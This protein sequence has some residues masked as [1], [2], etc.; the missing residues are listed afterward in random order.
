MFFPPWPSPSRRVTLD[1]FLLASLTATWQ[2]TPRVRWHVRADNL[3]DAR[4]RRSMV[5]GDPA[6]AYTWACSSRCSRKQTEDSRRGTPPFEIYTRTGDAGE[7]GI[8]ARR[9]YRK[10]HPRIAAFGDLDEL[11]AALGL[12]L[13]QLQPGNIAELLGDVQQR[14]FDTGGG[15]VRGRAPVRLG[16]TRALAGRRH[17]RAQSGTAPAKG[18]HPARGRTG[19]GRLPLSPRRVPGA[20]NARYGPCRTRKE[21]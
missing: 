6:A 17:R 2:A 10:H 12:L 1:A 11:N 13:A 19:S 14:L 4:S 18:I 8:D 5:S 20:R 7:T 21:G 3:G 9:R 16:G 15:V